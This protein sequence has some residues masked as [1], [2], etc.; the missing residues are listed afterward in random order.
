MI[1]EGNKAPAFNLPSSEGGKRRLSELAGKW[2]VL[3]FYPRDNTSGCT[4]EAKDFTALARKFSNQNAH[5]IG[6]SKDSIESHC[7]FIDKQ[8][9]TVELLSDGDTK[10]MQKYGVWG[11]KKLYGKTSMGTIRTTVVIDEGGVV[12][13]IYSKVRVN[14]HATAV[15]EELKELRK[16][17]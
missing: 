6:V 14:E 7:K 11:E 17:H 1:K 8:A 10:V 9:L 2:V 3:F 4:L 15:L 12:R 16:A 5:V 13:K